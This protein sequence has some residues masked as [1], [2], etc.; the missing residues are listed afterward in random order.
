MKTP[1]RRNLGRLKVFHVLQ[2]PDTYW[3][4]KSLKKIFV[5]NFIY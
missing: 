5:F 1:N 2:A 4:E 3:K